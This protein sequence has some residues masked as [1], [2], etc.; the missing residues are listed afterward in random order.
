MMPGQLTDPKQI[1]S[2]ILAGNATVTFRSSKTG[3]RYTFRIREADKRNPNDPN[4]HFV[5][6][7]TGADNESSYN[8]MGMIQNNHF[9]ITSKSKMGNDSI[10]VK[11]FVWAFDSFLKGVV[12]AALQVWHEGR[13][14]KCGRK[15]TVPESI[16]SGF[17]PD[18]VR[19]M[20]DLPLI[21]TNVTPVIDEPKVKKAKAAVQSSLP[22]E[23]TV[24]IDDVTLTYAQADA[25]AKAIEEMNLDNVP[26]LK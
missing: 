9:R 16:A 24:T 19:D 5:S 2:F 7:L 25:T 10:P 6:L 12:P 23:P 3:N 17:G 4:T 11:T 1:L 14:G 8:Y 20:V 21:P 26:E 22:L 18:C 15:L 13:C